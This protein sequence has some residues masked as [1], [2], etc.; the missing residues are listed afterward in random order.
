MRWFNPTVAARLRVIALPR[1]RVSADS[2][3]PWMSFGI[4][5]KEH[6]DETLPGISGVSPD[7]GNGRERKG[8]ESFAELA[9]VIRACANSGR[10]TTRGNGVG[11]PGAMVNLSWLDR[12]IPRSS[13][14]RSSQIPGLLWTSALESVYVH[15][16]SGHQ[17][18]CPS[19]P[20]QPRPSTPAGG[21]AERGPLCEPQTDPHLCPRRLW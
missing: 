10:R 19:T 9:T 2:R 11:P 8:M 20:G 3:D 13:R 1:P 7:R 5:Y 18:L 12:F 4:P 14:L 21:A 15:A 16:N 6:G 17:A